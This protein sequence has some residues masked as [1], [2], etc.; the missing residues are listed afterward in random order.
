MHA[1]TP[2]H[3]ATLTAGLPDGS[4]IKRKRSGYAATLEQMLLAHIVDNTAMT[5][6]LLSAD[7]QKGINRPASMLAVILGDAKEKKPETMA[8]DSP[9]DFREAWRK[10]AEK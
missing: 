8:F 2:T 10:I 5:M 1:Y 3:I 9:E 4:R 6:W 7:G